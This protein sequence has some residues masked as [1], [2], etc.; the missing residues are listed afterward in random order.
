[1]RQN[2]WMLA[3]SA[4]MVMLLAGCMADLTGTAY[5]RGEARQAQTVRY[6]TVKELEL[7]KIEGT[8]SGIGAA[9]GAAV[10][11]IGGSGLGGGKGTTIYSIAG[12]LGGGLLGNWAE[13]RLTRKQGVNITIQL[14][15][16]GY[17]SVVQEVDPAQNFAIGARVKVL[18]QGSATRVVLN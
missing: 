7:V 5:S 18:D 6:G 4:V 3:L 15:N 2:T 14:D 1:M 11:G 10:G 17:L 16:G 8:Q 13:E 9:T 12:A